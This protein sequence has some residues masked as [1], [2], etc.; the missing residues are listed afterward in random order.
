MAPITTI[1]SLFA[2]G[3]PFNAPLNGLDASSPDFLA[4][5]GDTKAKHGAAHAISDAI[6]N[7][8]PQD[9]LTKFLS[10]CPATA[11][12]RPEDLDAFL[13][14]YLKY[15][16]SNTRNRKQRLDADDW[17]LAFAYKQQA[18][19]AA[20]A[21]SPAARRPPPPA[22]SPPYSSDDES[23]QAQAA[24]EAN[25][26]RKAGMTFLSK[27]RSKIT[28]V[29]TTA[30]SIIGSPATNGARSLFNEIGVT[31]LVNCCAE[32]IEDPTL[33]SYLASEDLLPLVVAITKLAHGARLYLGFDEDLKAPAETNLNPEAL[34]LR[35]GNQ[36]KFITEPS[37]TLSTTFLALASDASS[38]RVLTIMATE[39]NAAIDRT[40]PPPP[41]EPTAH[42]PPTTL[43]ALAAA[44]F[45]AGTKPCSAA[46]TG[47]V[48]K[49]SMDQLRANLGPLAVSTLTDYEQGSQGVATPPAHLEG[50][51]GL[52][53]LGTAPFAPAITFG[54]FTL[55]AA[56][57]PPATPPAAVLPAAAPVNSKPA[58][59]SF[60]NAHYKDFMP[61]IGLYMRKPDSVAANIPSR[62]Q[63]LPGQEEP[64]SLTANSGPDGA[65]LLTKTTRALNTSPP[66]AAEYTAGA[67]AILEIYQGRVPDVYEK[68]ALTMAYNAFVMHIGRLFIKYPL[69]AMLK[70]IQLYD[71]S[72]RELIFKGKACWDDATFS[73]L[74]Q[75]VIV[76]PAVI[77]AMPATSAV[78]RN[79]FRAPARN[80]PANVCHSYNKPATGG[81][82]RDSCLFPHVCWTCGGPHPGPDCTPGRAGGGRGANGGRGGGRAGR[83]GGRGQPA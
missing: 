79:D 28:T 54:Q 42:A 82:A 44:A 2:N 48:T 39:L 19:A 75:H 70:P 67:S 8:N 63:I 13:A 47:P 46:P 61:V 41:K 26:S 83:G 76:V 4:A 32:A 37:R 59:G 65:F 15:F 71:A 6:R 36:D 64:L 73:D 81:C 77:A 62:N 7:V 43:A 30:L 31:N 68:L 35:A 29:V 50:A 40:P 14:F 27:L 57:P 16:N 18:L 45:S 78:G 52:A 53:G 60:P 66:T 17:V 72:A 10:A 22:A 34:S 25:L 80:P 51:A 58:D 12:D 5:V 23:P 20:G 1:A 49:L 74:F 69:P 21:K 38:N 11:L 55:P 9:K 56:A 3:T 24:A 33:T